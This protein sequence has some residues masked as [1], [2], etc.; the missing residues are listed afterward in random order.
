MFT[1]IFTSFP[2]TFPQKIPPGVIKKKAKGTLTDSSSE[3]STLI[4]P[5]ICILFYISPGIF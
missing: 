4:F 2:P 3:N 5:G 1:G